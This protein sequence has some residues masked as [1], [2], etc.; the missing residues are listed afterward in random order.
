MERALEIETGHSI[1]K[2]NTKLNYCL[3]AVWNLADKM[4]RC[5]EITY[6]YLSPQKHFVQ[7]SHYWL[8]WASSGTVEINFTVDAN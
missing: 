5:Q 6:N 1:W 8:A 4:V 2:G 7:I 3:M